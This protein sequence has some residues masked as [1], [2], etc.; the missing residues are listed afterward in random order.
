[1]ILWNI[2]FVVT[3]DICYWDVWFMCKNGIYGILQ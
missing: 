2:D 3:S 1:M